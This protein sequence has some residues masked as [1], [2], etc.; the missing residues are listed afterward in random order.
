MI[1]FTTKIIRKKVKYLRIRVVDSTTILVTVPLHMLDGEMQQCI[2]SKY[3]RIQ[4]HLYLLQNRPQY[5]DLLPN[6]ILLHWKAYSLVYD[7]NTLQPSTGIDHSNCIIRSVKTNKTT[8]QS[9]LRTWYKQ[10]A[11]QY[12][13]VRLKELS[14]QHWLPYNTLYIR[15]Q[16]TKRWTCSSKRN[17]WL[18]RRLVKMPK[19]ISDYILCHELAHLVHM[20][21]SKDFWTYCTKVFPQTQQARLWLKKRWHAMR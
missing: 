19:W 14:D 5:I 20:N 15:D 10:Y 2:E 8:Y 12:L 18:N 7:T 4:K 17:I 3:S 11:K 13:W 9:S 21:H 1:S 16:K 6:Q